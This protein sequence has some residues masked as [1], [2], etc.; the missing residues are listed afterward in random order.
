MFST[1]RAFSVLMIPS[2]G[3]TQNAGYWL[4]KGNELCNCGQGEEAI[5]AYDHALGIDPTLI[6]ALNN[7]GLVLA[8]Q[9]RFMLAMECF[10]QVLKLSPQHKHALSNMGMIL[11]QQ[12]KYPEAL[13]CFEAAIAADAYF[14]GAWYNMALVLQCMNRGK[15]AMAAMKTADTLEGKAGRCGIR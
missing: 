15:E 3:E 10:E 2:A 13:R 12:K 4:E 1:I 7:K 5:K 11:A 6:D 9:E 14:A 8:S